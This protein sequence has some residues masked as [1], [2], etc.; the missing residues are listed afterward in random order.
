MQA[1]N[2]GPARRIPATGRA[3]NQFRQQNS[4]GSSDPVQ[5]LL[6]R[7]EGVKQTGK[8]RWVAFCPVHENPPQG[9]KPSL[10]IARGDDGR[11][12]VK[13]QAGC[14]T[15]DVVAAVGKTE[16]DLYVQDGQRPHPRAPGPAKAGQSGG[17]IVA[18]YDYRD[19][20]GGLLYQVVRY[21]PKDFRQRRP[22]GNGGWIWK[23]GSTPRVLYRLSELLAAD[24]AE[25]VF[26]V[27]GEKDV[28]NLR[29]IGLA[30]TT[31]PGGKGKWKHLSDDSA[32]HGRRVAVIPD[33]DKDGGGMLHAQ[34]VAGRLDGKAANVRI[35]EL[36]G[37][38]KDASIWLDSLDSKSPDDLAAGLVELAEAAPIWTPQG[39]EPAGLAVPVL[40]CMADVKP[41]PV[42]WLW[43]KRIALGKLTL[44]VGDPGLGKSFITLDMAARISRGAFW[45][46]C[47]NATNPVGGVVLL[48]AEDDL[49]DTIR[50]RLDAAGANVSRI[51][52]LEAVKVADVEGTTERQMPFDLAADLDAL[53]DAIRQTNGCRLVVLDPI[54]AYLGRTDS[55][56]NAEIRGLLAPLSELAI[57]H[58]VAVVAVTHLRKGDGPAMYR[59]MGSLAFVA[60]ARAAFAVCRDREDLTGQRRFVL[61][62]KN[63]IGNDETGLAYSLEA[64]LGHGMPVVRW[65]AKPVDVSVDDVLAFQRPKSPGPD[66]IERDEATEWLQN[67]LADGPQP[68]KELLT[69]AGKDGI[70]VG[71]L[72]RAKRELGVRASKNGWDGGWNWRLPLE[73]NEGAE[74]DQTQITC[75]PSEEPAPLRENKGLTGEGPRAD[76]TEG[77]EG[78][79]VPECREADPPSRA[80]DPDRPGPTDL[81]TAEQRERYQEAYHSPQA[82]VSPEERHHYA[83]R[84]VTTREETKE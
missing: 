45:P 81:L 84:A 28:D 46:D 23:M 2:K 27:E 30:A 59:A 61:P 3:K 82:G 14:A 68:A 5:G 22:N 33:N 74:H 34:D 79:Q 21:E 29:A 76:S 10:S 71:T 25:W 65:E 49:S 54:T 12:L 50:P 4:T 13:C 64:P 41:E 6:D 53:D 78:A 44:L 66:P 42:R 43:P 67:A 35:V 57:R 1:E 52:A 51:M 17:R 83:W 31:N 77:D 38:V 56:R 20:D 63:N 80:L 36:P 11:A 26:V 32:L 15:A 18:T 72:K 69:Q 58:G 9:H 73:A 24:P 40:T 8:D 19:A 70:T 7:L 16:A 47:P 39:A 55:H 48:S 60:A 62:I 37:G 75:A